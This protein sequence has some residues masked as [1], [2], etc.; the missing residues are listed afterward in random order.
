MP[1]TDKPRHVS[2]VRSG[3]E[4]RLL[5]GEAN[6]TIISSRY[7]ALV[8][9]HLWDDILLRKATTGEEPLLAA[10]RGVAPQTVN[11]P[12]FNN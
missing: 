5:Q 4:N 6:A 11:C 1:D 3:S 2:Y 9:S 7:V 12:R 8:H 10:P